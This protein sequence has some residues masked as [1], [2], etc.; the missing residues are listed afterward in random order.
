MENKFEVAL[1]KKACPICGKLVD[2]PIVINTMLTEKCANEV[3]ELHG[4]TIGYSEEPCSECKDFM[5]KGFLVIGV[6]GEKTDDKSNPY[7]SGNQWVIK[8]EVA[9]EIFGEK[10]CSKGAGFIDVKDAK[11]IGLPLN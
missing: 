7:R 9:H 6:I 10:F 3:K 5:N 8:N 4:K 2:G 11:N 1:V